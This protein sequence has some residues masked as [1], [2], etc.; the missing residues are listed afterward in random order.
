MKLSTTCKLQKATGKVKSK[1][2]FIYYICEVEAIMDSMDINEYE[3]LINIIS[4]VL[5]DYIKSTN[6]ERN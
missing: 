5:L 2:S 6:E 3:N 1:R 4:E